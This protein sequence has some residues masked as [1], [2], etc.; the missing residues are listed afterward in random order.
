MPRAMGR[1]N[2]ATVTVVLL[3]L[4]E[5]QGARN[6]PPGGRCAHDLRSKSGVMRLR[7]GAVKMHEGDPVSYANG[8]II[9]M[10]TD[11]WWSRSKWLRDN[12]MYHTDV[13]PPLL[14]PSSLAALNRP[15]LDPHLIH[16]ASC[17]DAQPPLP[18]PCAGGGN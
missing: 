5:S 9:D 15:L 13:S 2:S 1:L 7:G 6:S 18:M 17:W 8:P 4:L 11:G 14:P 3:G 12:K 16:F 10:I